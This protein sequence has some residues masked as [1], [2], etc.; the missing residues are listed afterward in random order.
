MTEL[1]TTLKR[2]PFCGSQPIVDHS[3]S[4]D[5]CWC[6]NENC[7]IGQKSMLV[8]YWQERK[9]DDQS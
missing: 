4:T 9:A 8:S 6:S 2:C 5:F 7:G 1:Q 3:G